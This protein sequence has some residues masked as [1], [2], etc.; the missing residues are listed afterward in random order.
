M[1][2]VKTALAALAAAAS[3]APAALAETPAHATFTVATSDLNL[4]SAEGARTLLDRIQTAANRSCKDWWSVVPN[5][6]MNCR[7]QTVADTVD[8][9]DLPALDAVYAEVRSDR[10]VLASAK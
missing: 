3:F 4:N 1:I 6:E 7:R 2:H 5:N 9:L 8:G 10:T